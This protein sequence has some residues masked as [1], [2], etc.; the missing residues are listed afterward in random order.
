MQ[1]AHAAL[2][3]ERH[4]RETRLARRFDLRRIV[5]IVV[6][7]DA[8]FVARGVLL[9]LRFLFPA[10]DVSV[11]VAEGTRFSRSALDQFRHVRMSR[12]RRNFWSN[13]SIAFA[14]LD[15]GNTRVT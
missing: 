13:E 10:G 1:K 2:F 15:E 8:L 11:A 6:V 12:Q 14:G 4:R 3:R 7:R 5:Q 9:F